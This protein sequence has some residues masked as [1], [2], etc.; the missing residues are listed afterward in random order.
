MQVRVVGLL[1]LLA[2]VMGVGRAV[3][4]TRVVTGKITSAQTG[5]AVPGASVSVVGTV[6]V[7]QSNDRGEYSLAA[8]T[9]ELRLLVRAVGFKRRQVTVGADQQTGD[10]TLEQDIFNLDAVVVTGQAT[11]IEQRNLPNAVTSITSQAVNAAPTSTIESAL[12]GKVPGALI[13]TN[14]G[15]P[16][17]GAQI[18]LRG[19][20]TINAGSDPIIVVDGLIISN[21]AIGNNMNSVTNAAGGGNASNQDNPVNRMADLNPADIQNVEIMKGSSAAAI[22]GAQAANGVI[23]IT[24]KRGSIGAPAFH[25]T[26]RF[27]AFKVAHLLES[28]TFKDSVEADAVFG[29]RAQTYCT[30]L[31]PHYDN[32]DNLY[33]QSPLSFETDAEVSGGTASTR[34]FVS[35]LVKRDGGI[36][37]NTGYDKQAIRANLDQVLGARWN[38]SVQSQL[39]HSLS[40]RGISNNDNTG[41]SPYLVFPFTPSFFNLA[42]S[43]GN[44]ISDYPRNP[45]E[46]SNP[47]QTFAFLENH[48]DVWRAL[49][50]ATVKFEPITT[51]VHSLTL[52]AQGGIDNFAQRNDI[53]SPPE[54]QYEP[55]DGQDGT[56]VLGKASNTN[57]NLLGNG[58]YRYTPASGAFVS[59]TSVSFVWLSKDLNTTNLVGRTL[60]PILQ[61]VDKATSITPNQFLTP[62]KDIGWFGQEELLLLDQRLNVTAGLRG[63]RSGVN[64]DV[65]K[66]YLFPKVA[67]SYRFTGVLGDAA[68]EMKVRLA[69]G[70]TGNPPNF[71]SKFT[72][73]VT[74]TIG[75]FYGAY[76]G[77]AVG[78]PNIRPERNA[79]VEA[80]VDA[81]LVH[82]RLSSNLTYYHRNITDLLLVQTLAPSTGGGTRIFNGGEMVKH[83]FEVTVGY[84]P[85]QSQTTN[86]VVRANF[87]ADRTKVSSLPVPS[88]DVGGFGTGLGAFRV[89]QGKSA[90]QIIGTIPDSTNP[91]G[92]RIVQ[93]G[94][95][96]P[97]FQMSFSSDLT[98]G[99]FALGLLFD[100]K[101]G[102]DVINL[103][104]L[105][106]D[107]GSNSFDWNTAGSCG[108]L[109]T[110]GVYGATEA[111]D[112]GGSQRWTRFLSGDTRPYIQDASYIKLR[113]L[114]VSYSLPPSVFGRLFGSNVKGARLSVAAR[115][116]IRIMTTGYRGIDPEVSNFGNQAIA[117]NIDVAPFPPT[118][119]FF[120]SIDVDF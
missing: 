76:A 109:A 66:Y 18:Q 59:T 21:D 95:A 3:A 60:P 23:I 85:I 74:G 77:G 27:G 110:K 71:Q 16:G 116:L 107:A 4:Q 113:E 37:V 2:S 119:S 15:A 44:A 82:G 112:C 48:E 111:G 96:N 83:G 29:S 30:P 46:R 20:S 39:I 25:L 8:P 42:P 64:G 26:Q 70:Q 49:A 65:H 32:I 13:Q 87:F 62:Q 99:R 14:S 93:V 51:A 90:T 57:L 75:G 17:G 92:T 10:F 34:Y 89:E 67:G 24:T 94:D 56:V 6:I 120:F 100:W 36:A 7:A 72:P 68:N 61:G 103:T 108:G 101:H 118:R 43:G 79:E 105:L 69:Y 33:G 35:G 31:C 1:V 52:T 28:R 45:F 11:S 40:A 50:T 5:Q 78:D 53:Y 12:Q 117:R 9:G 41:T 86:W 47:L 102:G 98:R 55:N 104:E 91:S 114:S 63:D 73:S 54:L 84:A 22:Y 115:N 81:T 97:D 19:V 88:F 106:F 80:G 58:V 38:L